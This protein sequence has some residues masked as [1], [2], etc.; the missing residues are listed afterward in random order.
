MINGSLNGDPAI[1]SL[2]EHKKRASLL[3]KVIPEFQKINIIPAVD[4]I[5]T[6]GHGVKKANIIKE[7]GFQPVVGLDGIEGGSVCALD[8]KYLEYVF[9]MYQLYAQTGAVQ[10]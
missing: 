9:K 2:E 8:G 4:I 6:Q 1:L 7:L 10:I 5:L 3:T